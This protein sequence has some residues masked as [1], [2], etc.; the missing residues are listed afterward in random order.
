MK[1]QILKQSVIYVLL[2]LTSCSNEPPEIIEFERAENVYPYYGGFY[3]EEHFIVLNHPKNHLEVIELINDFNRKT[4]TKDSILK[5]K[6][7]IRFFYKKTRDTMEIYNEDKAEESIFR[8]I[9]A[10]DD[11]EKYNKDR[12]ES[13]LINLER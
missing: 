1:T 8:N 9:A 3:K 11:M 2:V 5:Y 13:I 12:Q 7:Y 6:S 10:Y 4:M